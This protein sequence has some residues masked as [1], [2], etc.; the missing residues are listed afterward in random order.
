MR[1]T[2]AD[3]NLDWMDDAACRGKTDVM[4]GPVSAQFTNYQSETWAK[5]ALRVCRDCPVLASC[6]QW[7]LGRP[8]PAYGAVAGGLTPR[9]RLAWRRERRAS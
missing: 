3:D 9:Q 5:P 4:F 6:R 8:D 1:P 7:A 2:W